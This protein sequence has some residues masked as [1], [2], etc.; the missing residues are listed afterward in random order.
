MPA[1]HAKRR[2]EWTAAELI[3][4]LGRL[5][6]TPADLKALIDLTLSVIDET[7]DRKL[8]ELKAGRDGASLPIQSLRQEIIKNWCPCQAAL[9]HCEKEI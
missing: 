8:A 5:H 6:F 4:A 7:L 2:D 3:E 1:M 9:R